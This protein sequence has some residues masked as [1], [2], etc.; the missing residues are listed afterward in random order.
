MNERR[1]WHFEDFDSWAQ[2]V[3]GLLLPEVD[4]EVIRAFLAKPPK[5]VVGD[6]LSWLDDIVER[7]KGFEADSKS[8]LAARLHQ[9]YDA[10]RAYHGARPL[11]VQT[12]YDR[13]L[14]L[15][16]PMPATQRARE[17]FLSGQFP[18]I[19]EAMLDAA[20]DRVGFKL[21]GGRVYFETG[22]NF[23]EEHCGH[24]LLYGSEFLCGVAANLPGHKDYRQVLKGFGQPTVFVCDV[25]LDYIEFDWVEDFAGQAIE[26]MFE[27]MLDPR[28]V[29]PPPGRGAGIM[30]RRRLP[31]AYLLEHYHP[32]KVRDPLLGRR[33]VEC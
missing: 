12:Y 27:K 15:L 8:N 20:I 30:L 32:P 14:E 6:D 23:L 17:I 16:D 1:V 22:K 5:Y 24:Y 13:G 25:P 2:D 31:A 4:E 3:R 10:I 26:S 11:D 21:R 9:R 19:D 33:W 7:V 29:H 28:F 18:E